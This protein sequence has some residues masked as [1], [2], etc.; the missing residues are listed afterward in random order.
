[1]N[2]L[3]EGALMDFSMRIVSIGLPET[4]NDTA[5]I[6]LAW[7]GRLDWKTWIFLAFLI[8]FFPHAARDIVMAA[9]LIGI[10]VI[11]VAFI[12]VVVTHA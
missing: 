6:A 12:T 5:A 10:V 8:L 11:A 7:I 1:M 3:L 2:G 4:M 9:I